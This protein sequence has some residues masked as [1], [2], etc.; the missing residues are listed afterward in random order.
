MH[1]RSF[2]R[3]RTHARRKLTLRERRALDGNGLRSSSPAGGQGEPTA[4]EAVAGDDGA[5]ALA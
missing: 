4:P 5:H 3:A 1:L 2:A